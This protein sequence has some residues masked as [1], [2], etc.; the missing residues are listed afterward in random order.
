MRL[1]DVD[2][3]LLLAF[4]ALL[5]E[6]HVTRAAERINVSQS[7]MSVSFAKLRDLFKDELL[8]R[9][10]TGLMPTE[11]AKLIWPKVQDAIFAIESVFAPSEDFDPQTATDT[12]RLIVVD[13]ID[14]L[15]MPAVMSRIRSLAPRVKV[16]VLQPDPYNF[17]ELMAT[18]QLDLALTY[19]PQPPEFLKTRLLFQDQFVGMSSTSHQGAQNLESADA[20]CNLAHITIEID[21]AQIYNV[22][23]ETLLDAVG[24]KRN[25]RMVKPSFLA[26]HYTIAGSDLVACIPARLASRMMGQASVQPFRIPLALTPFE[27]RMLWHPRSDGSPAQR[28]L[29]SVVMSCATEAPELHSILENLGQANS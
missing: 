4:D 11:R 6:Q 5:R 16:Q 27:V 9:T 13:Y 12:F 8:M 24:L 23:I 2:L 7:S 15:I 26:L 28:W 19:F 3:N 14:T 25:V 22:Q 1:R 18:G 21:A 20:F 29:R 17:G 10:G